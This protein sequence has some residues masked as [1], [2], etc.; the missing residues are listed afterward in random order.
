MI[1]R[2]TQQQFNQAKSVSLIEYLKSQGHRFKREGTRYR[3]KQ[4]DSLL[5]NE[6]NKW[7]WNSRNLY[8]NNAIS[9]LRLVENMSLPEAVNT[10]TD[11]EKIKTTYKKHKKVAKEKQPFVMPKRNDNHRRAFA[12][13]N[14]TRGVNSFTTKLN[15]KIR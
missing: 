5:I 10:L 13:L 2:F 7:F 8:G 1:L 6:N 11:G 3:H 15:N 12:Y 4:H 9:Y 14:K